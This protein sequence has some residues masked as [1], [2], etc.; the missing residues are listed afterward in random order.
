MAENNGW[1]RGPEVS[2]KDVR[3]SRIGMALIVSSLALLG[4]AIAFQQFLERRLTKRQKARLR[5]YR[6]LRERGHL[7]S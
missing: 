2:E 5:F 7:E 3:A 1:E 6:Y 4:A